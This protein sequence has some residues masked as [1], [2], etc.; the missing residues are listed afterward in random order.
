LRQKDAE[1]SWREHDRPS[2]RGIGLVRSLCDQ[3]VYSG[4]GNKV[5]ARYVLGDLTV[6]EVAG[7][8]NGP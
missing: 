1:D 6:P 3:L 8:N 4:T 7:G 2:G 5:W